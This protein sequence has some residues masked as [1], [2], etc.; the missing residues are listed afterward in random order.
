M[1]T[2]L[3]NMVVPGDPDT[4]TGGYIYDRRIAAELEARGWPISVTGLEGRF[5]DVDHRAT[6][7]V[8][9]FLSA[10]DDGAVV[11]M[12]GLALSAVPELIA[13]HAERLRVV[14]LVHLPLCD[15]GGLDPGL[16]RHYQS[17]E[18][19]ALKRVRSVIVTSDFT[20]RRLG[21]L[22]VAAETVRVVEPGTD[23]ASLARGSVGPGIHMLCA[24]TVTPRKRHDVLMQALARLT[25]FEWTLTCAGGF[26]PS[27]A[28]VRE[29]FDLI[30]ENGL[31]DRVTFTGVKTGSDLAREFDAADLFV[32]ASQYESFGMV[33]TEALA[34]G[35]P[36]VATTGG[37]IPETVPRDAGLLVPPDDTAAFEAAL[38]GLMQGSEPLAPLKAGAAAARQRLNGWAAAGKAF[39][40]H[41]CEVLS[42]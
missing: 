39:E 5:P 35:L 27:S 16:Q 41:L 38:S 6:K 34:H 28:W 29:V 9:D 17:R 22:G 4:K 33:F 19:A 36:I 23:T 11:I 3:L 37:A 8:D 42:P 1:N 14:A 31:S 24:A 30:E 20:A 40:K 32:L 13:Q 18:V 21:E 25:Q 2:A 7:S 15:E 10:Q 12:D 26:D